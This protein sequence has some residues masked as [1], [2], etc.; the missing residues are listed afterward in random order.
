MSEETVGLRHPAE[1]LR[2]FSRRFDAQD[3]ALMAGTP[4]AVLVI[5]MTRA[6][7]DSTTHRLEFHR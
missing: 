4:S 1:D 2:S 7:I 6:F 3:R 5:E